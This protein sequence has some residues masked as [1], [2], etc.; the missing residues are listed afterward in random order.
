MLAKCINVMSSCNEHGLVKPQADNNII[1]KL[2][3]EL[4]EFPTCCV[5][6]SP[7]E[8]VY[9]SISSFF[10]GSIVPICRFG[11]CKKP[12]PA[13]WCFRVYC[14]SSVRKRLCFGIFSLVSS[15]EHPYEHTPGCNLKTDRW[16]PLA[17]N[18]IIPL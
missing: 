14:G 4:P 2:Q 10:I 17:E 5:K 6:L 13:C 8:Y 9:M 12:K 16:W 1:V 7:G 3:W 18:Y 15:S 11:I